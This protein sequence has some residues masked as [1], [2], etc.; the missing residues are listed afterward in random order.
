MQTLQYFTSKLL[1]VDVDF[2][3]CSRTGG[4]DGLV[5]KRFQ[6]YCPKLSWFTNVLSS[7]VYLAS[8]ASSGSTLKHSDPRPSYLCERDTHIRTR[9]RAHAR[10]HTHTSHTH[11]HRTPANSSSHTPDT[12]SSLVSTKQKALLLHVAFR[13]KG[14]FQNFVQKV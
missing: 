12:R 1:N 9:A 3:G 8:P 11:T 14:Y 13:C 10:A 7:A 4:R 6:Q 5:T 2:L